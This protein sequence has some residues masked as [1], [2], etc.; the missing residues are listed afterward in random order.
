MSALWNRNWT[1]DSHM[2]SSKVLMQQQ[3]SNDEFISMLIEVDER[4]DVHHCPDDA[5]LYTFHCVHN[6][7]VMQNPSYL[8]KKQLVYSIS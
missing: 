4:G 8:V 5:V 6:I 2:G 3:V 1:I 7:G